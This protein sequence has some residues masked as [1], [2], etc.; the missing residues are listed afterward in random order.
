MKRSLNKIKNATRPKIP[1]NPAE[2]RS[3]F[4]KPDIF[5]KYGYNLDGSAPFYVD[6]VVKHQFS[7]SV[8]KS[9]SVIEIIK[10][11]INPT[12]RH[13]L[14]DGTFSC[15]PPGFYQILIISVE[16]QNDVSLTFLFV[17]LYS[18][19]EKYDGFV[20][21]ISSVRS[22]LSNIKTEHNVLD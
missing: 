5:A 15:V 1:Q 10:E 2:L 18:S 9:N 4:E 22:S 19:H 16:Y 11:N 8:F 7:F 13:Y 6:T 3:L 14:I 17:C 20:E 12:Q 21:R